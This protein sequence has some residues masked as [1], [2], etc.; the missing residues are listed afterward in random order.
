MNTLPGLASG[1][2]ESVALPSLTLPNQGRY[3][4]SFPRKV[5]TPVFEQ[6]PDDSE[7]VAVVNYS[8]K[9]LIHLLF[10]KY[11]WFACLLYISFIG[12]GLTF[13]VC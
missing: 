1:P 12:V 2:A 10:N 3:S 5:P 13:C 4:P 11:V 8:G 6:N 9:L 7:Y